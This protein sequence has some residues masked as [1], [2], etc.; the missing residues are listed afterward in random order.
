[1]K[2]MVEMLVSVLFV[3]WCTKL[4]TS[5]KIFCLVVWRERAQQLQPTTKP[6]ELLFFLFHLPFFFIMC[7]GAAQQKK[8]HTQGYR[9]SVISWRILTLQNP[10]NNNE[11]QALD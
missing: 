1:M 8:T 7:G 3:V 4:E 9:Q 5:C 11:P 6:D 10:N 2:M